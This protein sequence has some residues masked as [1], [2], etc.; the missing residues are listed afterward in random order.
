MAHK[1]ANKP[2]RFEYI[3]YVLGII[4]LFATLIYFAQEYVLNLT[5]LQK[6]II[7][8]CLVIAFFFSGDLLR[9]RDL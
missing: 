1:V 5:K 8:C 3:Y 7:L 6:T 2:Y 9:E 4:F